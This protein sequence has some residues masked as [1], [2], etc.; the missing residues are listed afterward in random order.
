MTRRAPMGQGWDSRAELVDHR[1]VERTARRPAA[2][3]GLQLRSAGPGP[4][5]G[6]P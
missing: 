3:A 2:E 4:V 1:W 5:E 6:A